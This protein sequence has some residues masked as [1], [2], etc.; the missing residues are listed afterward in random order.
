[1]VQ[2]LWCEGRSVIRLEAEGEAGSGGLLYVRVERSIEDLIVRRRYRVGDRL[3][4]EMRL[5]GEL[6]VSRATVRA[7]LARLEKRGLVE[8]RQG[9]GTFLVRPPEGARLR[10]GLE[11][12]ETY[13]TQAAKLGLRLGSRDVR[14]EGGAAG[15]EESEALGVAVGES[16]V[17]LRRVLLVD[18]EPSGWMEDV[19]PA[20]VVGAEEVEREFRPEAMLLDL[21]VE[22]GVP[23]SFSRLEIDAELVG[24]GDR[25]GVALG[26][27]ET[28]AALSLTE[29]MYLTDG[30]IAQHSRNLF[31]PGR[32][33]LHVVR[34]FYEKR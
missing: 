13:T 1:M 11:R 8:R 31:L 7:G 9:S 30:G 12:L 4:P 3:P 25:V 18:G 6:G 22:R 27:E 10:N 2:G 24:P 28:S 19:V 21:L 16:V 5:V 23:V 33:D 17:R 14:V 15:P 20:G 26:L 34:E 32:L 29:T